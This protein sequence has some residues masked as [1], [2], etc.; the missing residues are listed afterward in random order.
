MIFD[1]IIHSISE[2]ESE[3]T[4][5]LTKQALAQGY[6]AASI[7]EKGLIRGMNIIAEKYRTEKVN[8]PEVLMATQSMHAG[9]SV[10]EPILSVPTKKGLGK[11]I[12]GT[13]AGDLHD[14]GLSIVKTMAMATG[15]KVIDLGV[16]VSP[17]KFAS[18]VRK[19]KPNILMISA[20]LTT[21][22]SVMKD[23]IDE[24]EV[25]GLRQGLKIIVGGAPITDA[26]AKEIGADYTFED[27]IEFRNFLNENLNKLLVTKPKPSAR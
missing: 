15:A 14:I 27:A 2:G 21:T 26:F 7:L 4:I 23:V 24:L 11:I 9:L 12:L 8:V 13:V 1:D 25:Q 3:D 22:M 19:E 16:N 18:A 6:S 10:I 17:K 20:L 5:E